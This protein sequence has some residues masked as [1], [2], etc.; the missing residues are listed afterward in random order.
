MIFNINVK[1]FFIYFESNS[2]LLLINKLFALN[3][4]TFNRCGMIH[5]EKLNGLDKRL[6]ELVAPLIMNPVVLRKNRNYTFKTTRKY[7]WYVAVEDDAVVSFLPVEFRDNQAIINNYYVSGDKPG[8]LS[9]L[10]AQAVREYDDNYNLVSV[11]LNEHID[12]FKENGFG[13]RLEWKHYVKMS[14]KQDE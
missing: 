6:Y 14:R 13:V 9:E 10:I 12:A 5:I 7:I 11:T 4:F 2:L 8:V 3:H 1:I